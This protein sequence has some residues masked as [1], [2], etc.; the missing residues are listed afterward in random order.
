L[1]TGAGR[2]VA[3]VG[4]G[5][6]GLA[7]AYELVKL[8][9][10][11][12]VFEAEAEVGGLAAGFPVG[13]SRIERFYHHWFTSDRDVLGLLAEL[14]L[15]ARVVYSS[16]R[17]GM[18]FANRLYR[19]T[20]PLDLIR[21][22]P[23]SLADRFRLGR[24]ILRARRVGDWRDIDDMSAAEWLK[25]LGGERVYRIVWEPLLRGK[26]GQHSESVSASWIWSKLRLRGGSRGRGGEERLAYFRGGFA[27]LAEAISSHVLDHGG[28]LRL[29]S[30][31]SALAV[32]NGRVSAVIAGGE[33]IAVDAVVLT[34]APPLIAP[35]L[36]PHV[37]AKEADRLAA[38]DYLANIC[39]VLELDRSLSELYWMNVNDPSFP[40]VGVI[41]HTHLD[42]ADPAGRRHIVYL[43]RYLPATDPAYGWPDDRLAAFALPNLQRMFPAFSKDW[44]R[45]IHVWRARYAQPIVVRGYSRMIP[46][47]RTSVPGAYIA[48]MAQVYPED[49]GTN[50]AI[51]DGRKVAR[52]VDEWLRQDADIR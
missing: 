45:A 52:A 5:F 40:F 31:V 18:Y 23:L 24:L 21:F 14:S 29:G 50:Y 10:R 38:I 49:R 13:D 37:P 4:A 7:A 36:A 8:G 9:H 44:I 39:I 34:P 17:T 2:R 35:L 51:R 30:T 25:R 22:T 27:A 42:Q 15:D 43:S 26:F 47:H 3:V 20:K 28:E 33:S 11:P 32:E 19:L 16:T 6:S 1:R 41:E 48:S 46:D 12:I